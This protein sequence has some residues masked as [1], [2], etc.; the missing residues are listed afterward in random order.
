MLGQLL[1]FLLG[2]TGPGADVPRTTHF[3]AY[4]DWCEL[5]TQQL[6]RYPSAAAKF[7]RVAAE[8]HTLAA[9]GTT[10]TFADET[11]GLPKYASD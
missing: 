5:R 9:P 8:E 11:Y 7:L 1:V 6:S 4:L 10:S 2:S 3:T